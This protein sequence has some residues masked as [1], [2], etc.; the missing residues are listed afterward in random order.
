MLKPIHD[1]ELAVFKNRA[2]IHCSMHIMKIE[3]KQHISHITYRTKKHINVRYCTYEHIVNIS[4]IVCSLYRQQ[5]FSV[6]IVFVARCLG[7]I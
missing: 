4:S 7:Y 1:A 2:H 3:T 6:D 5:Q